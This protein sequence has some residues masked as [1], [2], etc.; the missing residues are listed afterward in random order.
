MLQAHL[1]PRL[2]LNWSEQLDSDTPSVNETTDREAAQE[3]MQFGWAL[4]CILQAVWEAEPVQVLVRVSKLDVIDAYHR[5]TV[6]LV[7]VVAFA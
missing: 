7:Q 3:L 1:C 5:G 2:I 6:N 4:P